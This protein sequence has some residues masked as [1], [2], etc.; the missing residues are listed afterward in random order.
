MTQGRLAPWGTSQALELGWQDMPHSLGH[1]EGQLEVLLPLRGAQGAVVEGVREEGV[2]QGTE[3]HAVAPAGGEVLQVHMLQ[4]R[5]GQYR[6]RGQ[7][8]PS[9]QPHRADSPSPSQRHTILPAQQQAVA[10]RLPHHSP[11]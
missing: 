4:A 10:A 2:D 8:P 3:G 11:P 7:C 5:K 9:I 6:G 1:G